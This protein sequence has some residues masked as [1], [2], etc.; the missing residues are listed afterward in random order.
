M[1][2]KVIAFDLDGTLL[3]TRD[4][5]ANSVNHSLKLN[6]LKERTVEEVRSFVNNGS[7]ILI[8]KAIGFECGGIKYMQVF[9]DYYNHYKEN[10]SIKTYPYEGI[11]ELLSILKKQGYKLAVFTNKPDEICQKLVEDYFPGIFDV[12]L[13][14]L[15]NGIKKPDIKNT[16]RLF[17]HF[18]VKSEEV[19]F[20]GDSPVDMLTA[21]NGKMNYAIYRHGFTD[22]KKE[23][24]Q[25]A[26][27]FD[28]PLEIL[29]FI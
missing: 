28:N 15:L 6:G 5:L 9:N 3:E 12:K 18:K 23:D 25:P 2:Y 20:I 24:N 26:I 19:F 17:E 8:K 11:N 16:Q 13:G 27:L 10:C 1:K 14:D 29:N 22:W 21:V 4:D 7:K